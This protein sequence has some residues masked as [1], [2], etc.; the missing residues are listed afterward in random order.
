MMNMQ[1]CARCKKLP[2]MVFIT[3]VE[4][5]KTFN[6]GLC[7]KCAGE[8]GIKPVNDML[9]KMGISEEEIQN[10]S[11]QMDSLMESVDVALPDTT[12]HENADNRSEYVDARHVCRLLVGADGEH[13]FAEDGLVPYNPHNDGDDERVE[14]VFR[15]GNARDAK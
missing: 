13:I 15:H 2:A 1:K 12:E 11:E 10:M 6:E 5:G 3:R 9:T 4:N 14:D 7:L 8:L